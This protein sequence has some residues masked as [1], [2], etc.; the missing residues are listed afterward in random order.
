LYKRKGISR[1]R[2]KGREVHVLLLFGFLPA[3]LDNPLK[4]YPLGR[5]FSK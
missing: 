5:K 2:R 1:K 4:G 3:E